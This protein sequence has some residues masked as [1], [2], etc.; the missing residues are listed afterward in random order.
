MKMRHF[1]GLAALAV[2]V[3]GCASVETVSRDVP[4]IAP[5]LESMAAQTQIQRSY[6]VRD[7]RVSFPADLSISE[8]NS[9]YP[10]ADVVWRGDPFGDRRTQ[11]AQIFATS[12]RQGSSDL[13]GDM[14]VI[15]GINVE[16]FHSLT[17]RTRYSIGG[18][19]SIR[20]GLTIYHGETGAI[21]EDTRIITA[22]LV[23]LGGQ[24]AVMAEARG[25]TQKSRI[26]THLGMVAAQEL[27][28]PTDI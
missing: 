15:V 14:P 12:F 28:T 7:I 9:Y 11:I 16:R 26:I 1:I 13:Q 6:D 4:M 5:Q 19:H 18:T 17:E 10:I 27:T 3:A 23:A 8:A 22:D 2:S 21:V 24:A 25:E 20:F